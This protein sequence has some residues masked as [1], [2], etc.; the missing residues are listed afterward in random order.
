MGIG[1]ERAKEKDCAI[2][3]RNGR[4]TIIVQ[5]DMLVDII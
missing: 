1:E 5:N 4:K 3:D 2:L